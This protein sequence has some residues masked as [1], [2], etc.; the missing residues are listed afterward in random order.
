MN[1]DISPPVPTEPE[2]NWDGRAGT[3]MGVPQNRGEYQLVY[4]AVCLSFSGAATSRRSRTNVMGGGEK[5]RDASGRSQVSPDLFCF[6][7]PCV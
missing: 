2:S 3:R 1:S 7:G 5:A 4:C 6:Y